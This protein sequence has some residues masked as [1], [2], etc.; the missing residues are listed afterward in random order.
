[1]AG[2]R[3]LF[4]ELMDGIEA[5]KAHRGGKITLKSYS[6]DAKPLPPVNPDFIKNTRERLGLSRGV[7]A[8][9]LYINIRTLENWEQGRGRPNAQAIALLHLV[10]EYPDTLHR[11]EKLARK[12]HALRSRAIKHRQAG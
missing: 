12:T 10:H 9:K 1:M 5:M 2:K 4:N 7:F 3:N 6:V 8:R 11:L